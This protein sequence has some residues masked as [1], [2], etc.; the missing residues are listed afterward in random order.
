MIQTI[1]VFNLLL[2]L[3]CA[4]FTWGKFAQKDSGK[5]LVTTA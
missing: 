1:G 4:V 2:F 3:V 5:P